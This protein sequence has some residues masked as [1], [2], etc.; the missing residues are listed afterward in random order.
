[1]G[2]ATIDLTGVS[3]EDHVTIDLYTLTGSLQEQLFSGTLA[4][5]DAKRLQ[6]NAEGYAPG[7]YLCRVQVGDRQ[8]T[9]RVVVQ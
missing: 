3:V 8:R 4:A 1:M 6:W 7:V 2:Q 5:D 9:V